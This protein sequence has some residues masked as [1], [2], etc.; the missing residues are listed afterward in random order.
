MNIYKW[1]EGGPDRAY[2][3][4]PGYEDNVIRTETDSGMILQHSKNTFAAR[5]YAF[6]LHMTKDQYGL[7]DE[8]YRKTLCGG[9]A[10]FKFRSLDGKDGFAAYMFAEPPTADMKGRF[11]DVSMN[12]RESAL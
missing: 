6:G 5:T 1:P 10:P 7:F 3:I 11:V 2:D 12:V 4:Q 9:A 8:W